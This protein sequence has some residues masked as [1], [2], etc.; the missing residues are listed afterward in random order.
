VEVHI[1]KRFLS[2]FVVFLLLFFLC[3]CQ[4]EPSLDASISELDALASEHGGKILLY[5]PSSGGDIPK[6]IISLYGKADTP[7]DELALLD[8][9]VV[10]Y[11]DRF[12][13]HDAAIF[14]LKNATDAPSLIKMCMRRANTLY[15]TAGV[16]ATVSHDG[17]F[18]RFYN[19]G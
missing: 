3:S 15:L 2:A 10:W 5:R 4:G 1:L 19:L 16:Q 17:H 7:P 14:K 13:T 9:A 8:F 18:V 12:S 6:P 11:T